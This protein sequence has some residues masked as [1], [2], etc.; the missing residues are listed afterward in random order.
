M[1]NFCKKVRPKNPSAKMCQN[2][3][4]KSGGF[5][6]KLCP[7]TTN[8]KKQVC[9]D[10]TKPSYRQAVV[11]VVVVSVWKNGKVKQ[12]PKMKGH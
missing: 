12:P 6:V 3:F 7:K 4:H 9:I 5:V 10:K 11:V 2:E 1:L 8:A